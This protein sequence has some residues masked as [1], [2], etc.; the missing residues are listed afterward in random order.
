MKNCPV[1]DESIHDVFVIS[2]KRI[3]QSCD[4]CSWTSNGIRPFKIIPPILCPEEE[5]REAIES[6]LNKGETKKIYSHFG[7]VK[8]VAEKMGYEWDKIRT[9]TE[10]HG[11]MVYGWTDETE[12]SGIDWS[13]IIL[14][15]DTC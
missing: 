1:C 15:Q 13:L 9:L 3:S 6:S 14:P 11:L 5:I 7:A 2:E 8:A 4:K 10:H 12:G